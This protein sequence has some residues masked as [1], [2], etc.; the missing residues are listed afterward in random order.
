MQSGSSRSSF[1]VPPILVCVLTQLLTV[2]MNPGACWPLGSLVLP[3]VHGCKF[4]FSL[5]WKRAKTASYSYQLSQRLSFLECGGGFNAEIAGRLSA[6]CRDGEF[7]PHRHSYFSVTFMNLNQ[8]L[9]CFTSL[10]TCSFVAVSPLSSPLSKPLLWYLY[11][12]DDCSALFLYL[13]TFFHT[14]CN[15]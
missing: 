8:R 11:F 4:L 2:R 10:R 12:P 15:I 9:C 5:P 3:A 13:S 1:F 7:C 6:L 14:V